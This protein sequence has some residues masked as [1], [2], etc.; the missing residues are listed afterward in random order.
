MNVC[1]KSTK[2]YECYTQTNYEM[3][4]WR[5]WPLSP[6]LIPQAIFRTDD[7]QLSILLM[8]CDTIVAISALALVTIIL[9]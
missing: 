2:M 8:S 5:H 9:E 6:F 7:S 1:S 4:G 3:I